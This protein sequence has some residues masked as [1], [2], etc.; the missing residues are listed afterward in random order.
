MESLLDKDL[1]YIVMNDKGDLSKIKDLLKCGANPVGYK[2]DTHY[3]ETPF[4]YAA[5]KNRVDLLEIFLEHGTD[6][7]SMDNAGD[8]ALIA[9]IFAESKEAFDFLMEN[10]ANFNLSNKESKTALLV[11]TDL[12]LEYFSLQLIMAGADVNAHDDDY[13]SP[14]IVTAFHGNIDI[15]TALLSHGADLSFTDSFEH[16]AADVAKQRKQDKFIEFLEK[17]KLQSTEIRAEYLDKEK[18]EKLKKQEKLQEQ[19]RQNRQQIIEN[20]HSLFR[21]HIM[22]HKR[23]L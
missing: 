12:N 17:W 3:G 5:R 7:N 19:K 9:S 14:L 11:A 13:N 2:D 10:K 21:R 4:I 18:K 8:T 15:A 22:G 16:S 20:K 23:Q 6:I 1:A